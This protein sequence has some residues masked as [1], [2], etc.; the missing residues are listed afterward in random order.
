MDIARLWR[1]MVLFAGLMMTA[2]A[3][4]CLALGTYLALNPLRPDPVPL[5]PGQ[6][7]ALPG[8]PF[9]GGAA[10]VYGTRPTDPTTSTETLLG[11]VVRAESGRER[12]PPSVIQAA[13]ED[14]L[15]VEGRALQPLVATASYAEGDT[16]ECAGPGVT[17]AGPLYLAHGTHTR[18]EVMRTSLVVG[19]LALLVGPAALLVAA[20]RRGTGVTRR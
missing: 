9:T 1:P 20:A 8:K 19:G 5:P 13:F 18:G 14:D 11:C 15:V 4:V 7:V 12:M 10:V 6:A 3:V 17:A 16:I 2:G